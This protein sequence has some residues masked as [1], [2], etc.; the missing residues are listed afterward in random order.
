MNVFVFGSY[1]VFVYGLLLDKDDG[2]IIKVDLEKLLYKLFVK[3]GVIFDVCV[4]K[5]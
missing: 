2:G 1:C 5:G 4:K 3:Y